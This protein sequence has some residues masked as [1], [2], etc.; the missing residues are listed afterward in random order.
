MEQQ[1]FAEIYDAHGHAV[2]AHVVRMTS[3]RSGAEDIASL[4]FLEA[5][6]LRAT[7]GG[8][9]N[10]RAWLLGVATI[11]CATPAGRHDA[12]ERPSRA[13][14]HRMPCRTRPMESYP[15]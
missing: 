9:T 5:W 3:D 6:R 10:H 4:T 14:L 1:L 2:Y 12:T 13:Y 15:A 7:L 8:V 11:S